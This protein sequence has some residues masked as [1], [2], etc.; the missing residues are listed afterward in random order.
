MK[1]KMRFLYSIALMASMM[2]A[3][4]LVSAD[5]GVLC[6]G[7][8]VTNDIGASLNDGTEDVYSGDCS[9]TLGCEDY[10]DLYLGFCL[11]H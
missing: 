11:G 6:G 3:P 4:G 8:S 9:A 5:P 2:L 10:F 7:S 1:F